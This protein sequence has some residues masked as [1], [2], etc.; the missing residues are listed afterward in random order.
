[1]DKP[2]QQNAEGEGLRYS[3]VPSKVGMRVSDTV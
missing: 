3:D 2:S 1:M